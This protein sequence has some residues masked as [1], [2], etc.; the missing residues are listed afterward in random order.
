MKILLAE[1]EKQIADTLAKILI[2]NN[3]IVDVA[4]DGEEALDYL[5]LGDIDV[6]ILDIMMPKIDGIE[7]LKTMRKQGDKTPVL[8]LTAKSEVDDKVIGLDSGAD[9]YLTKPF[10]VKELLARLRTIMRR[11]KEIVSDT[12]KLGNVE[13][14]QTT[15]ELYTDYNKVQL[16]NKEFQII[17]MM[18]LHS[19]Q[20]IS[21]DRFMEKIWGYTSESEI[22]VVWVN[23]SN[24]RRKLKK[25]K[26]NI[27]IKVARNIGYYLEVR[28]G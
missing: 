7:V 11:P 19:N 12:V 1:D 10:A 13:L 22:N 24:L 20:K 2:K 15:F 8:L 16:S 23:L 25:L 3:Y 28:D 14:N 26:A 4:Y 21:T 5:S 9:D 18:M 17:E 6:V 27:E